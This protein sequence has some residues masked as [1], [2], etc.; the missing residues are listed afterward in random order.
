MEDWNSGFDDCMDDLGE[1]FDADN[2]DFEDGLQDLE[3]A[4]EFGVV[5]ESFHVVGFDPDTIDLDEG[6]EDIEEALDLA[7]LTEGFC[8]AVFLKPSLP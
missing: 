8:V 6:V 4:A 5:T 2:I 7:V 1:G 3:E